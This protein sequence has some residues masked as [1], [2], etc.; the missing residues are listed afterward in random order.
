MLVEF[1]VSSLAQGQK[2]RSRDRSKQT[3]KRTHTHMVYRQVLLT[4]RQKGTKQ[5]YFN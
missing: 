2:R 5:L 1:R 3:T 4:C